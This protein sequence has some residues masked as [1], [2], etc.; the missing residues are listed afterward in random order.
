[1]FSATSSFVAAISRMEEDD[2]S[3]LWASTSTLSAM[4]LSD[5]I[6]W[7]IDA[8]VSTTRA[9]TVPAPAD[10]AD[11]VLLMR[12]MTAATPPVTSCTRESVTVRF[13]PM[14]FNES[15]SVPSSSSPS[16]PARAVRSQS[17]TRRATALIAS[18]GR[19]RS[20]DTKK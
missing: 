18:R 13:S 5:A 3:A 15:A 14:R 16:L 6:I 2:S 7:P 10:T 8:E 17:E 4:P 19:S 20:L 12:S 9:V 11:P 1:M